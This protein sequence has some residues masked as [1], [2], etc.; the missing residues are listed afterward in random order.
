MSAT[1]TP[2]PERPKREPVPNPET[3]LSVADREDAEKVAAVWEA[4]HKRP[5]LAAARA[6]AKQLRLE[7]RE[8]SGGNTLAFG[9]PARAA[10][11]RVACAHPTI[12]T[13]VFTSEDLFN[14]LGAVEWFDDGQ[15]DLS[16]LRG[17]FAGEIRN[18]KVQL[19]DALPEDWQPAEVRP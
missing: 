7:R 11:G 19:L 3:A 8:D 13:V 18:G 12:G 2:L 5:R 14:E 17:Y 4:P 6:T 16:W 9:T 1:G 10:D 15:H